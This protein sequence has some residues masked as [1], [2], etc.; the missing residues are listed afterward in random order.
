MEGS[1]DMATQQ[2]GY[3]AAW[4]VQGRRV[5]YKAERL[6]IASCHLDEANPRVQ[7]LIGLKSGAM[8]ESD[9]E[10][11]LWKTN[12]VKE[13][14]AS[15]EANGGVRDPVIAE[16]QKGGDYIFKEGNCR[17]VSLRRLGKRHP[18]DSRFREV[19]AYVFDQGAL[20]D[21]DIAVI[22]SDIH[23]AGKIE[24]PAYE[25]ARLVSDLHNNYNKSLDW[26]A[27]HLRKGRS[28]ILQLLWAYEK[29]SDFLNANP[30]PDS[31][32]KFSFFYEVAKKR[33]IKERFDVDTAFKPRF[34]AW[35]KDG[36]LTDSK[37]V[38][39]LPAILASAEAAKALDSKG[40]EEANRVL[41]TQ[42]PARE[43]GPYGAISWA[44]EELRTFAASEIAALKL[45]PAKL[46]LVRN[47]KRA[48]EDL[49]TLGGL[50]L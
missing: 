12:A 11:A 16:R 6:P 10:D 30:S 39:S 19:E 18:N 17:L 27:D 7:Y 14:A 26:L 47:L 35:L 49:A 5:P 8:T 31:I 46:I 34:Y 48:L 28:K 32:R 13:L 33:E 24:W 43:G 21:E 38:R 29:T 15:I 40:F 3:T 2:N 50:Q 1:I 45:N 20:S 44:T 9:I 25:E 37:Q 22:L 23:V 36:R 41:I 42:D 4:T